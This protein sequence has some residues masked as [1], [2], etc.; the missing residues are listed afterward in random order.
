MLV[1]S[2]TLLV[3]LVVQV[4]RIT[5]AA[6]IRFISSVL[7]LR[8]YLLRARSSIASSRLILASI[9]RILAACTVQLSIQYESS[10]LPF[11]LKA[12]ERYLPYE[13]TQICHPI[14]IN[15]PRLNPSQTNRYSIYIPQ[16][17]E[18]LG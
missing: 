3:A 7:M 14:Q 9:S 1:F 8:R 2:R 6:F 5:S 11:H 10:T 17:A 16:K 18:R 15:V 12:T 13:I 4:H